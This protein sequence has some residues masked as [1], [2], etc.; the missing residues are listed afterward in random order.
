MAAAAASVLALSACSSSGTAGASDESN[1][2]TI[3]TSGAYIT[4]APLF[5]AE[6]KGYFK[7]QKLEATIQLLSNPSTAMSA[8]LNNGA[9]FALVAAVQNW[10]SDLSGRPV[11]IIG[12]NDGQNTLTL[13]VSNKA[14]ERAS[15]DPGMPIKDRLARL[16]G[17][18][19]GVRGLTSQDGSTLKSMLGYAGLT[20]DD[21]KLVTLTNSSAL[22]TSLDQG[23]IDG[24]VSGAPFPQQAISSGKAKEV[25]NLTAGEFPPFAGATTTVYSAAPAYVK[26]N[27]AQTQAFMNAIAMAQRYISLHPKEAAALMHGTKNFESYPLALLEDQLTLM[28][29]TGALPDNPV[30]TV[31]AFE[32]ARPLLDAA[33]GKPADI[34]FSTTFTSDFATKAAQYANGRVS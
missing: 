1:Q 19:F 20:T 10:Q 24:F 30:S 12:S 14:Y 25:A 26:S 11:T 28:T 4:Y 29:K 17:M 34:D 21:V 3:E 23:I 22:V 7:D 32:K 16:K 2:V 6:A 8:L 15:I 31:E 13:V 9:Q 5:V 18:S 33:I 27:P